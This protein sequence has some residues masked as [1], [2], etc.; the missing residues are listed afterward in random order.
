MRVT[1]A[2]VEYRFWF[3]HYPARGTLAVCTDPTGDNKY[4]VSSILAG[5]DKFCKAIGRRVSLTRLLNSLSYNLGWSRSD[6]GMVW[7]EYFKQHR[8]LRHD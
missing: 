7:A 1:I 4:Q 3:Q 2:G 8:D 6:R 5:G